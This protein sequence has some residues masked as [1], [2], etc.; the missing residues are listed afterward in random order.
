MTKLS[1]LFEWLKIS[2]RPKLVKASC[3]IFVFWII[4]VQLLTAI[5]TLQAAFTGVV[6]VFI[7]MCTAEYIQ[8][9]SGSVWDWL[10]VLAGIIVPVLF[11]VVLW[12]WSLLSC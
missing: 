4:A 3:F 11:T 5:S 9:S 6:C 10:D 2:N 7:V 12:I 1:N 8:K